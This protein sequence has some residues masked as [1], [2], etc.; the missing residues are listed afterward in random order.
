[1]HKRE[2]KNRR[3]REVRRSGGS[4]H[5]ALSRHHAG[6]LSTGTRCGQAPAERLLS[7]GRRRSDE[8]A[9]AAWEEV[10]QP[11][12][13]SQG[14][15]SFSRL[16][17]WRQA[18]SNAVGAIKLISTEV[19]QLQDRQPIAI[20]NTGLLPFVDRIPS[21][22]MIELFKL[23]LNSCRPACGFDDVGHGLGVFHAAYVIDFKST[24][25]PSEIYTRNNF[26][27]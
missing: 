26:R 5:G 12:G 16:R 24:R 17:N 19:G 27:S 14:S 15:A 7:P 20:R 3:S 13:I 25:K 9:T 2:E 8:Q 4:R 6:E 18:A 1:M 11:I 23:S 22:D 21:Q 10:G